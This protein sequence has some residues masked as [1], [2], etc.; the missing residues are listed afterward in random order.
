M[1]TTTPP[2]PE[3][4]VDPPDWKPVLADVDGPQ[5]VV[6]GPGAGKTEFLVRRA[7]HIVE[8]GAA[9]PDELLLVSFSRRTVADLRTRL[10][11]RLDRT[12]S[13]IPALT[14]HSLA[15]RIVEARADRLPGASPARPP[16]LLTG[17]EQVALVGD[18]LATEQPDRWPLAF[19]G[20]LGSPAF[21]DEVADF[22]LRCREH[23]VDPDELERRA[24]ARDDWDG[25]AAFLERYEA[26]LRTRNRIDYGTLQSTAVMLLDE[27]G[28]AGSVTDRFRYVLVDE[29]QDTTVA[30]AA[31]L[32]R[33]TA[34][35]RNL[36]AAGDP[37]QS[38]FSFRGAALDNV[39]RFPHQFAA[40][41]GTPGRRIVLTT[42]FRVP[43]A[44][45]DAAVRVTAG[46]DLPGAA[47][48]VV[49]APG[50]AA[51]ETYRFDQQSHEA[52]W[53]A[54][55]L[56]RIH[57]RDRIP[58]ARMAVLVRS[59]RRLL[60]ELSRA[61]DRRRIA[62]DQPDRRLVD[63]PAARI[64]FDLVRAASLAGPEAERAIRRLL[65]GP[66]VGLALG[67]VRDLERARAAGAAW[68]EILES[69]GHPELA[70]IVADGG[71]AT[72]R[73][74]ADGF[75]HV[76]STLP[77]IVPAARRDADMRRAWASLSQ[78]LG[79]LRERDPS[80]TLADYLR[81]SEEDDFEAT[82]LLEFRAPDED[83]LTLTSLH[84][85]KGREFDVVVIADAV[86]GV[87]P[88]LRRRETLLQV[89]QLGSDRPADPAAWA[90]FRLQEEM[91]LAYTAMCRARSRV[92]W[93]CTSTAN[94][95][96]A[97]TPSRFLSMLDPDGDLGAPA[98]D[99]EPVT[100]REAEAWLLAIARD[101]GEPVARRLAAIAVLGSDE[102]WR[103]RPPWAV[104]GVLPR[105]ADDGL[106]PGIL[107]L[108]PSQ[109]EAYATCPRRYALERRLL[110]DDGAGPHAALG[111]LVHE[112]LETVEG[113]AIAAGR[114]HGRLEDA[115]ALLDERFEPG[116]FGGGAWAAAWHERAAG[117]LTNLY[118]HWPGSGPGLTV[119]L[120]V[121]LERNGVRWRGRVDRIEEADGGVG[122]VDYKT[123]RSPATLADAAGSL[124]LGFYAL[125]AA[126]HTGRPVTAASFWYPAKLLKSGV[127]TRE[128][129]LDRLDDV[130][131]SLDAAAAG[132]AAERWPAT[133]S[134]ACDRCSVKLVCPAWPAGREAYDR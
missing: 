95:T 65:L 104:A 70:A 64:L 99:R 83:R 72:G 52:E 46:G 30:Q 98:V 4:R 63:H 94:E 38:I 97:G 45:L 90:S 120:P 61:L 88:D 3:I 15:M 128:F 126:N 132:I 112:V 11:H 31:L 22:L 39:A 50:S 49:P 113:E 118:E 28:A 69:A 122:V 125:A 119:E 16:T 41:D 102:P 53:I 89:R 123:S 13:G 8:S 124:Q 133:P 77:E 78:V 92:V 42:S 129:D 105:G 108:S 32:D 75:W 27:P 33:L 51:V 93:T 23:L 7:A 17:P 10:S 19:R 121:E 86:D 67:S 25:L 81:W 21:A 80:T 20:L 59:K 116:T 91:R 60:P 6:A 44:I 37:Y 109:A 36:T 54:G 18:L 82:P 14:F 48:P 12:T 130:L 131:A 58:Y 101:P 127:A 134:A 84:Q 96:G 66:L 34:G 5:L 114:D 71:W 26:E 115:L 47:G 117:I 1:P 24:A 79:R 40:P 87:F 29:F 73:P 2:V 103:P 106:V 55:E 111:S 57:R 110:V 68:A 74:A 76:W 100:P 35:H 43:A 62:H 107:E 9:E 56:E 85:A